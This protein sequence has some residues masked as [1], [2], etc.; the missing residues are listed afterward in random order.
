LS[1][2]GKGQKQITS[3]G[4]EIVEALP[5]GEKVKEIEAQRK[6][7]KRGRPKKKAKGA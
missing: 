1:S 7:P 6:K 2:V 3:H 4:E 5:D